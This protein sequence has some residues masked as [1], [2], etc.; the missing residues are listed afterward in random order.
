MIR[1]EIFQNKDGIIEVRAQMA[2]FFFVS[3]QKPL[4]HITYFCIF[5]T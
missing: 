3:P 2:R 4:R 5:A 1:E